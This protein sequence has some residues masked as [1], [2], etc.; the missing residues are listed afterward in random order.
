[1]HHW[2]QNKQSPFIKY[3]TH[4]VL[5]YLSNDMKTF[6]I[7]TLVLKLQNFTH[8]FFVLEGIVHK[9]RERMCYHWGSSILCWDQNIGMITGHV[10]LGLKMWHVYNADACCY[11]I[12]ISSDVRMQPVIFKLFDA[13]NEAQA[14]VRSLFM[15]EATCLRFIASIPSNVINCSSCVRD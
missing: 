6:S 4:P 10:V 3:S 15:Y 2:F 11:L 7:V 5:M 13:T 8:I 12:L 14:T 9:I 1:M